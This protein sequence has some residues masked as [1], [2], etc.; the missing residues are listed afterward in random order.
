[1]A[2]KCFWLVCVVQFL[3]VCSCNADIF[4]QFEITK[5]GVLECSALG[6]KFNDLSTDAEFG[7]GLSWTFNE[8]ESLW[9]K[10][11]NIMSMD[12]AALAM[13]KKLQHLDLSYNKLDAITDNLFFSLTNLRSLKLA[14]NVISRIEPEAFAGL[15][16]LKELD[17][18]HNFLALDETLEPHF[19]YFKSL[20]I[21]D[22]SY[23]I[24]VDFNALKFGPSLKTLRAKHMV[25]SDENAMGL[26]KNCF[27]KMPRLKTLVLSH[28]K[29]EVI[30]DKMLDPLTA[31]VMVDL[32]YNSITSPNLPTRLFASNNTQLNKLVLS[33]NFLTRL[34]DQNAFA[35]NT[36]LKFLDLS[37]NN[38]TL[39]SI[40][41]F[42]SNTNLVVLSLKKN[43]L[44]QIP[45]KLFDKLSNLQV[46]DISDNILSKLTNLVFSKITKLQT[47]FLS[48]N[49]IKVLHPSTF[50]FNVLLQELSLS[51]NLLESFP[52]ELIAKQSK[53]MTLN[54]ARNKLKSV[55]KDLLSNDTS[56][57]ALDISCNNLTNLP[58]GFF[59]GI[60][61]H[62]NTVFL[63]GNPLK[64][65]CISN[66]LGAAEDN[67]VT[68]DSLQFTDGISPVCMYSS[69]INM[70]C[71]DSELLE[72]DSIAWQR[73]LTFYPNTC[74]TKKL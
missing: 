46:L 36:N 9:M 17:L 32:S 71:N 4:C 55:T 8:V 25:M 44:S 14:N 45:D 56:L 65:L 34:T 10:D 73:L 23:N 50:Q 28:S 22:V 54:L 1:M 41:L 57:I 21:L 49:L 62:T 52:I 60:K 30:P 40:R 43:R 33:H 70:T 64:C 18:S 67:D 27:R 12:P 69:P 3:F 11:A 6:M 66:I 53:L 42:S 31:L 38:L 26:D 15:G 19:E 24:Y 58:D 5:S 47:L 37:Y 48:G 61:A 29:I 7:E 51:N 68:I 16:N 74:G 39:L 20:R 72:K 13:F 35:T 59:E 63:S 2:S